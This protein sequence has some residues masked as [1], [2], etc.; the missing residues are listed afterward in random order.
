[1]LKKILALVLA[2][3]ALLAFASCSE[4]KESA[5]LKV[6]VILVGDE[7]EGYTLAHMNGIEAAVAALAK[8]GKTVTVQYKKKIPETD[9]VATNALDLIADGCTAIITNS[10]GHQFHLGDI[11]ENNPNVTFV[12]MTGDLAAGSGLSNYFNAFTDVYESRYVSGVVAGMK[13]KSLI[14]NETLTAAKVPTAFDSDGNIKV[15]YVGAFEYAEVVSGYTAF[16]LG[17]KSVVPNVAMTVKYTKSWFSEEREAAVAEYL[18]GLGCVIIGQHADSTGAPAAVQ[19]AYK[20]KGN[21]CFSVGY[22]VSMLSVA[23][24]VALTSST[25]NWEVYYETLFRALVDGT[26]V[27]Q[28]WSEGYSKDAVGITELGKAAA[29]GTA[30]KVDAVKSAIAS[31]ALKVF[32]CS[33]FTVD[34]KNLTT[35]TGAYGMNNAECIAKDGD[36][37]FFNESVIRS[38]PYFDIRIDGITEIE[39]DY[40]D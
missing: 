4:K 33:T 12:A 27:P 2:C 6:G 5:N 29:A 13:L 14:D 21:L 24:D 36:K 11:V 8:D 9:A 31:G 32:N 18:M 15:G 16:Y 3:T 19:K 30:E 28:D 10:Y 22:N 7:T 17:I 34:G 1:M 25:N 40:K 39:S 26:A 23:P 37:Y 38:A 35:Y 20:D